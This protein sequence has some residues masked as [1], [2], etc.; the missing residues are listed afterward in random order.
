[1]SIED[2]INNV[3]TN[4]MQTA[5]G[6]LHDV[7]KEDMDELERLRGKEDFSADDVESISIL[8]EKYRNQIPDDL[9]DAVNEFST[10]TV[11]PDIIAPIDPE[12]GIYAKIW[13]GEFGKIAYSTQRKEEI[14]I[15][16]N[17][18]ILGVVLVD[19]RSEAYAIKYRY[20]DRERTVPSNVFLSFAKQ[21]F[22][23]ST[24]DAKKLREII[25]AYMMNEIKEGRFTENTT[26][27]KLKK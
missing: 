6:A 27:G 13:N 20:N 21:R 12:E 11:P 17:G 2:F 1:M 24:G 14:V 22:F 16:W 15:R 5:L 8:L 18:Y 23:L 3:K 4:P 25:D 19:E 10:T 9:Y 26:Q 7:A